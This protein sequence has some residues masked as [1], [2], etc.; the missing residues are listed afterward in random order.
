MTTLF[1][2]YQNAKYATRVRRVKGILKLWYGFLSLFYEKIINIYI[3]KS[4][5][6]PLKPLNSQSGFI[7]SLTS[8]PDR[9]DKIWMVLYCLFQQSVRPDEIQLNLYKGEFPN[10]EKDLPDSLRKY[11]SLGL[12]VRFTSENL[13]PHLKYYYCMLEEKAGEK[14]PI[15]TVD[16]DL[17]YAPDTLERLMTL[18]KKHPSAIVGNIC[19]RIN[20]GA[21]TT[22]SNVTD[23]I[24]PSDDLLAAGFGAVLYPPTFYCCCKELYDI[25]SIK[26]FC[27]H[28]DD[29]WLKHCEILN[30]T[31]VMTGSY[32]AIPPQI[33]GSQKK[34]LSH[35][36][37]SHNKNDYYWSILSKIRQKQ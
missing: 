9:I 35:A 31:K 5:P 33:K 28:A 26:K 24:G 36:N 29:L 14:R 21:Y 37:V 4:R 15:I 27:L 6:L 20:G 16:D 7:V 30:K 34:A 19:K 32:Y 13:K 18:H 8:F 3:E 12:R 1:Y 23:P 17:L 25:E 22:W 11:L 2:K 10:G